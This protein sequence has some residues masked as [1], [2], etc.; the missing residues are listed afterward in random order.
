[1]KHTKNLSPE[2]KFRQSLRSFL[3]YNFIIFILMILGLGGATL[4]KISVIWGAILAFKGYRLFGDQ[5]EKCGME[6]PP[7]AAQ[8]GRPKRP[9]WRKKD[10]V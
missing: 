6:E 8:Y 7:S 2:A 5:D 10:L 1:M 4:W 9:E 3:G